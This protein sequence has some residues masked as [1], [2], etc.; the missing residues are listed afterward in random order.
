MVAD[1]VREELDVKK[2]PVGQIIPAVKN[3]GDKINAVMN[4]KEISAMS[5]KPNRITAAAPV[6]AVHQTAEID[7]K[8][9]VPTLVEFQSRNAAIPDWRLKMQNAVRQR[10]DGQPAAISAPTESAAPRTRLVTSGANALKA[11]FIEEPAPVVHHRDERIAKALQRIEKSRQTYF[12]EENEEVP[13]AQTPAV[14][15]N[16]PFTIA[17]KTIENPVQPLES[18]ASVNVL[19]KPK[20][21]AHTRGA[22]GDLD[23][24]K[25]SRLASTPKIAVELPTLTK[26]IFEPA[27]HE[28]S[29]HVT[30]NAAEENNDSIAADGEID[31]LA[32]FAMR[33]NA[34][35]FDLIIGSFASLILLAPFMLTGGE[36]FSFK[37][38]LAFAVTSSIVMFIYMTLTTGFY[39]RT[40]GMRLFSL[41]LIDIE[42]NDYPTFH[43]AAV[44]SAVYLLSLLFGGIGFLT[45]PFNEEK[46]AVH[47][48]VSGTIVVREN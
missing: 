35:L 7:V 12:I 27:A 45:V 2:G 32:P 18:K 31:D 10:I 42:E 9:T 1:S 40:L 38:F 8:T 39:G 5:A 41:E 13:A 14:N 17:P 33:F 34:G 15:K 19:P 44:N 46:R 48:L 4:R 6:G 22:N 30:S 43:Q 26:E 21:V 29:I 36:W 23:T 3:H 28:N 25:L 37:G 24:N 20:L 16:F 47:D 11:Q